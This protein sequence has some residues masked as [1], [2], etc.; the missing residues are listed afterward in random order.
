MRLTGRNLIIGF[1][2]L[3]ALM[4]FIVPARIN[5]PT[6]PARTLAAARPDAAAA[7]A[8]IDRSCRD[9]H[10]NDTTWPWYSRVAPISWL[11]VHDVNEGRSE[12]NVSEFGTYAPEKQQ[13]KLEEACKEVTQGEMPLGSY[14]MMHPDATLRAGDVERI[15]GLS[16]K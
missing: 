6:D 4:Q 5:P 14:L 13:R 9:C 2:V 16:A 12:F 8:V 7:V 11:V 10:S 1:A 15:C 3:L